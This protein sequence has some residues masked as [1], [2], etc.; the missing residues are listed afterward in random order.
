MVTSGIITAE[1][2]FTEIDGYFLDPAK[3][4]YYKSQ[5]K[6]GRQ[7]EGWFKAELNL[8]FTSLS[9]EKRLSGWAGEVTVSGKKKCDYV[10]TLGLQKIYIEIKAL[11][12][13]DWKWAYF[14]KGYLV[15]DARKLSA[16]SDGQC[17]CLLFVY[18][19]PDLADWQQRVNAFIDKM[20]SIDKIRIRE[21]PSIPNTA[22]AEFLYVAK[23]GVVPKGAE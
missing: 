14:G 3:M 11:P 1:E 7:V 22:Y 6:A 9:E 20:W 2:L 17:F 8:F 19:K 5:A 12:W 18:P 15:D 13:D 10:V 4:P 21:N 23:L 16:I